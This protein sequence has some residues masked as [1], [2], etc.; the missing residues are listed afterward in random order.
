MTTSDSFEDQARR[1]VVD[2]RPDTDPGVMTA[3]L[4]LLR[5]ANLMGHDFETH[6]HRP[7]GFSWAGFRVML[8]LWVDGEMDPSTL[9]R[10]SGVSRAAVSSVL[11][12][13]ERDDLVTRRPHDRDG[14]RVIVDLS[15]AGAA[16]VAEAFAAQHQRELGWMTDLD[17]AQVDGLVAALRSIIGQAAAMQAQGSELL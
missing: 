12:T 2:A 16:I 10:F 13:L 8:C 17:P 14:R 4:D 7:R 15:D 3:V 9:A 1:R 11:N 5:L 6:V